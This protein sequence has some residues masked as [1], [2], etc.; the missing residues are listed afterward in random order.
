MRSLRHISRI[1]QKSQV[2]DP[3]GLPKIGQ[4]AR[5]ALQNAAGR[6]IVATFPDTLA[7]AGQQAL[8]IIQA[9]HIQNHL[10]AQRLRMANQAKL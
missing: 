6:N 3:H 1:V 10:I 2:G 7:N 8:R 5:I 9:H 4:G